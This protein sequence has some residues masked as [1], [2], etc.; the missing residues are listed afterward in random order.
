MG[1]L[2][3]YHKVISKFYKYQLKCRICTNITVTVSLTVCVGWN[4]K[5]T[6]LIISTYG[7]RQHNPCAELNLLLKG[8][9][10]RQ[11][12]RKIKSNFL[13]KHPKSRQ[14]NYLLARCGTG[15]IAIPGPIVVDKVIFL[16]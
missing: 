4:F 2:H 5:P 13:P 14:I 12:T 10:Y 1:C 6:I 9:Y 3:I 11:K 7:L 15:S 16:M 8:C